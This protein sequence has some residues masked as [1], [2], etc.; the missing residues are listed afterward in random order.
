M[1]G[2]LDGFGF[3]VRLEDFGID[4][5]ALRNEQPARARVIL[6]D[7]FLAVLGQIPALF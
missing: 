3:G 2:L 6:F 5:A 4:R 1:V 7:A